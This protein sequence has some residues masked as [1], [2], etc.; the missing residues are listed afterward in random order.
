MGGGR[1]ATLGRTAQRWL[2]VGKVLRY[3]KVN[4]VERLSKCS[5]HLYAS[6]IDEREIHG[7]FRGS[8]L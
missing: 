8:A 2:V 4:V 5:D 7:T 1:P 3:G 6:R